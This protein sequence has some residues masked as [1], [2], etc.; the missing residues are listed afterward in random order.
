MRGE[1]R[2]CPVG[3]LPPPLAGLFFTNVSFV[4]SQ[5]WWPFGGWG[6]LENHRCR[7][8]TT[9]SLVSLEWMRPGLPKA[10]QVILMCSLA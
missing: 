2:E 6:V 9:E 1:G 10:L 8:H 7:G 4:S 3:S 5:T